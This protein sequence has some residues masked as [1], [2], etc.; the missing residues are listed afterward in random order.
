MDAL[1][2]RE[3]LRT[4]SRKAERL[5]YAWL[6]AAILPALLTVALPDLLER[7]D[8]FP[9][10]DKISQIVL[11]FAPLAWIFFVLLGPYRWVHKK[12]GLLCPKC[13]HRF[14]RTSF[15]IVMAT[16]KCG[17]CGQQIVKENAVRGA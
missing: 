3:D 5:E 17:G 4:R 6:A 8:L 15:E 9:D 14:E 12:V 1:V 16:G 13:S 10:L 7:K 11:M 2:T